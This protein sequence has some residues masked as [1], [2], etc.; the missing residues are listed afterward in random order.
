MLFFYVNLNFVMSTFSWGIGRECPRCLYLI[1]PSVL[2]L[3]RVCLL[4][5]NVCGTFVGSYLIFLV[6]GDHCVHACNSKIPLR[7]SSTNH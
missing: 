1:K 5:K 2:L 3:H 7:V 6:H 4:L